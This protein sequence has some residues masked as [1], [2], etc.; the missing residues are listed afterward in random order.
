MRAVIDV[1]SNSVLLLVLRRNGDDWE[2]VFEDAAV[3][4]LGTGVKKTGVIKEE[5]SARTLAAVRSFWSKALEC[6]STEIRAAGTMAFR[7]A[8]NA[9]DVLG[10]AAEQGTPI[11]VLSGDEE[12]KLGLQAVLDDPLFAEHD[13]LTVID[14]GGH[15]T[16]IASAERVNGSWSEVLR[17]SRSIGAFTLLDGP[18]TTEC[19]GFA[20]RLSAVSLIDDA[21]GFEFLPHKCG[22]TVLL[23]AAGTNLVTIRERITDWVPEKV[24]GAEIDYEEVSRSVDSLCSIT[25]E[26]RA[27][28]TG[29]EPGREKTLHASLLIVERCLQAVHALGCTVSIR[30]WRHAFLRKTDFF[31]LP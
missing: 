5:C 4:G 16:E 29:I 31:S 7:I 14:P 26:E 10:K 21:I 18:F 25:L 22:H 17:T 11:S 1:G 24:H 23:G 19:P 13:R 2:T 27:K 30:G 20:E 15:S 12:A 3:T 6:G 9:A 28:L 8:S